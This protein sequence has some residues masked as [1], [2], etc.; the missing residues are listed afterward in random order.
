MKKTIISVVCAAIIITSIP[1]R[2]FAVRD[3][4]DDQYQSRISEYF[5]S[6][7]G[8]EVLIPIQLLG[9]I[10]HPG[11]YHVPPETNLTTLLSIAGGTTG[12]ANTGNVKLFREGATQKIDI[13]TI[14]EEQPNFG[15]H[16]KDTIYI[17]ERPVLVTNN[18][19]SA[20]IA[21]STVATTVLTV[22]WIR[23]EHKR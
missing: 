2:A 19:L 4:A 15:L 13:D 23:D 9:Q 22:Y 6:P 17:P 14:L 11:L 1:Q 18:T 10:T 7:T 3:M 12:T 21:I 5:Y 8:K 16:Q 20:L